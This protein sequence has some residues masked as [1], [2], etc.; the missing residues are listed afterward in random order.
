MD[1]EDARLY[2]SVQLVNEWLKFAEAKNIALVTLNGAAI[3]GMHNVWRAHAPLAESSPWWW[4]E[5]WLWWAT[6][7]CFASLLVGLASL[8]PKTKLPPKRFWQAEGA[9]TGAVFY[10]HLATM[11][12]NE[13]VD[14]LVPGRRRS[15]S[16]PYLTDLASQA[17]VNAKIA[18][19]KFALFNMAIMLTLLGLMTPVLGLLFYLRF[20]DEDL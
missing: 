7:L 20:W 10:A 1:N 17:V 8:F 12:E 2:R 9:G 13:V 3:V 5:W 14:R 18:R 11:T 4:M 19:R 16:G 6:A 15:R